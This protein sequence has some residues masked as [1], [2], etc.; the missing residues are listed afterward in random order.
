M[1]E[2]EPHGKLAG[3]ESGGE[4][5]SAQEERAVQQGLCPSRGLAEVGGEYEKIVIFPS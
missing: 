5:C 4:A 1:E 2:T 3:Y